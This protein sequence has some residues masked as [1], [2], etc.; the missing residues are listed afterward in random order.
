MSPCYLQ[1]SVAIHF[2]WK[3]DWQAVQRVLPLIEER[4]A[5]YGARPHWAKLF[6]M[7]PVRLRTLYERLPDFRNLLLRCD[8]EG[9]FRNDFLDAYVL[10]D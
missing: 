2:T 6:T 7:P 4:L 5:P 3:P 8:P 10:G 9:K 1:D